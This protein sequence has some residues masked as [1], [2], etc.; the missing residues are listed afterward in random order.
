MLTNKNILKERLTSLHFS[1]RSLK[2]KAFFFF[3]RT[4]TRRRIIPIRPGINAIKKISLI[5]SMKI[6]DFNY[7][8]LFRREERWPKRNS[9]YSEEKVALDFDKIL[10]F[11]GKINYRGHLVL[12][13]LPLVSFTTAS[14]WI[15]TKRFI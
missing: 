10:S 9:Y 13:Y 4:K 6:Y 12:E 14:G 1:F 5:G 11:L 8:I 15:K 7:N 3:S 2:H